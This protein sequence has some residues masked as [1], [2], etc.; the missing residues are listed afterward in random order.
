MIPL[1]VTRYC[2]WNVVNSLYYC[3]GFWDVHPHAEIDSTTVDINSG[4]TTTQS[5]RFVLPCFLRIWPS[6]RF[7]SWDILR[8]TN[9]RTHALRHRV[10]N[11]ACL[12]LSNHFVRLA[13]SRVPEVFLTTNVSVTPPAAPS[14]I[15]FTLPE[16]SHA[17]SLWRWN[18]GHSCQFLSM[19]GNE[20]R[21]LRYTSWI[22]SRYD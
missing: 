5:S 16:P 9:W 15:S 18:D 11:S 6:Y 10:V 12:V 13:Y 14:P 2:M 1:Y 17:S 7:G 4:D 8:V 21:A 22:V 3:V 19:A 20:C